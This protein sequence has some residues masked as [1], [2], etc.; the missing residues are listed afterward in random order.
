MG[1]TTD[2]TSLVAFSD[3][4]LYSPCYKVAYR[5]WYPINMLLIWLDSNSIHY[6][7]DMSATI[8]KCFDMRV[9]HTNTVNYTSSN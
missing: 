6:F 3:F 9:F 2:F 4:R 5:H 1:Y 7:R 8:Q